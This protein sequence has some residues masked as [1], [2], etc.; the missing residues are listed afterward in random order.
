M[1]KNTSTLVL[2]IVATAILGAIFYLETKKG[3]ANL[4][5]ADADVAV[6]LND[7]QRIAKKS[8]QYDTAKEIIAPAGFINTNGEAVN[9]QDLIGQKVIL[10]DFWTYSCINCQRTTPYLTSW[11]EK[12]RDQGLEIVGVHTPE[13]EFE[14]KLENVQ[15]AVD[16]WGIKYPVVLDNDYGTWRNYKNR[17]W[18]RKYLIDIDGF[19]VYDH[20][21][22]GAYEETEKKIQELLKE[23]MEV[24]QMA[25]EISSDIV[26]PENVEAVDS[27]IRRSPETY[28]GALRNIN[29]G[30]GATG[31]TGVQTLTLPET[32]LKDTLYLSGQWDIQGEYAKNL[33]AGATIVFKFEAQ[34]VFMV[35]RADQ[36]VTLEILIDGQPVK[37]PG[38]D[39]INGQAVIQQD[40]LYRL[41]EDSF[42]SGAHTLE[43]IVTQPGLEVFT[44]TFG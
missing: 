31:R 17:Y 29:F 2:A 34:K 30:N 4:D 8:E 16:Q 1:T 23:R 10:V 42:G 40:R 21:G 22:E 33:A 27:A 5:L 43:I 26:A 11:Y 44:F 6:V 37:I 19:I 39:V 9:L 18:P 25:G 38:S 13:F 36:E 14:K 20:I 7:N 32:I 41:V 3:S 28:F 12:Y 15:A 24:L 35:A